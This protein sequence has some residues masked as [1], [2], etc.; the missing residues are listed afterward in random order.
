MS[1][2]RR[3]ADGWTL[4]SEEL[5]RGLVHAMN[6]RVTSMGANAE[7]AEMDGE[8]LP[9]RVMR[10]DLARLNVVTRM[11]SSIASR[12]GDL[13]ALELAP[14]LDE[15]L[16]LHAHHPR[17]RTVTCNVDRREELLPVR[18]PRWALLRLLLLFVDQAKQSAPPTAGETV[19]RLT[20]DAAALR[21]EAA[22]DGAP[23]DDA[24]ALAS[25]CGGSLH[26]QDNVLMLELPSLLELRRR[27]RGDRGDRGD[28]P[29]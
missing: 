7:L 14:L 15:V 20:G 5:L 11:I 10:D 9:P 17:L 3:D 29:T 6:N 26:R 12:G 4:L 16:R 1:D 24:A 18:V 28:R 25:L 8:K 21:L 13:E 2:G 23:H 22:T 19:L 27:E